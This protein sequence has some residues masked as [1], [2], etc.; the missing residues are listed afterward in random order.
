MQPQIFTPRS[1]I[2]ITILSV[3]LCAAVG[4]EIYL[5]VGVL[6]YQVYNITPTAP[7]LVVIVGGQ[8]L[9]AWSTVFGVDGGL[10]RQNPFDISSHIGKIVAG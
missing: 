10:R 2:D 5:T 1:D 7:L 4:A 3:H 6:C 9:P 8:P